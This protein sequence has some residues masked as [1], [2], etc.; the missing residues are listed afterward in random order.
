VEEVMAGENEKQAFRLAQTLIQDPTV[1]K[2]AQDTQ[3]IFNL[4]NPVS[5]KEFQREYTEPMA[6]GVFSEPPLCIELVRVTSVAQ[7]EQPV[8][9]GGMVHYVYKPQKGG[10]IITSIDGFTPTTPRTFYNFVF[11]ITFRAG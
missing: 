7:T 8:R 9:S 3:K 10:A 2:L 5:Y 6:L 4:I 1:G 11:R